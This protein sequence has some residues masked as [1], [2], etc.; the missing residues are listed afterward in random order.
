MILQLDVRLALADQH[1]DASRMAVL[2]RAHERCGAVRIAM[3]RV[4][5]LL[6]QRLDDVVVTIVRG[7]H[8]RGPSDVILVQVR[9]FVYTTVGLERGERLR[10]VHHAVWKIC[11]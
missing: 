9:L 10:L 1:L 4:G 6:E 7:V 2:R 8:E 11:I 3:V 5:P